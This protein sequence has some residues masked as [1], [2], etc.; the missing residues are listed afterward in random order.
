MNNKNFIAYITC[1]DPDMETSK[2]LVNA[3]V[4][5]GADIIE[6]GI[7]FSDPTAVTAI[8]Q[9]SSIRALK[10]GATTDTVFDMVADLR[11]TVT[12]P[13]VFKTYANVVF[14]YGAE[15]FMSKCR[16]LDVMGIVIPDLPYEEK[17]EFLPMCDKYGV[18]LISVIAPAPEERIAMIAKEAK[19]F[20]Y[21]MAYLDEAKEIAKIVRENTD[22]PCLIDCC[23]TTTEN[24]ADAAAVS[25]G[26]IVDMGIVKIVAKH[27]KSSKKPVGD[28]VKKIR[29]VL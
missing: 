9:E 3:A 14:S 8:M 6:L 22:I 4:E 2:V 5:N 17:E 13:F 21:I 12:A 16:E 19:G 29:E 28:F 18:N 23:S 27:G 1:G 26:V 24:A 10:N 20:V 25:D 15:K 7:P 11:K